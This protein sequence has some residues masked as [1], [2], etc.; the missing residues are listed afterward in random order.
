MDSMPG[1]SGD[2]AAGL[3]PMAA[4]IAPPPMF[5]SRP[6]TPA[7]HSP[8]LSPQGPYDPPGATGTPFHGGAM[9]APRARYPQPTPYPPVPGRGGTYRSSTNLVWWVLALL[10]V[11]AGVGTAMAL[12]FSK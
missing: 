3:A 11:G 12:L 2:R 1:M 5:R 10:A 4:H 8:L 9:P 7:P 6:L